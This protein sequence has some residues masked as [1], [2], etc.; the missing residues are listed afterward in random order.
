M[1]ISL[2]IT[3]LANDVRF[4]SNC[5]HCIIDDEEFPIKNCHRNNVA[6]NHHVVKTKPRARAKSTIKNRTRARDH[7]VFLELTFPF[8]FH[9]WI[10]Q[11]SMREVA[12][13]KSKAAFPRRYRD[14]PLSRKVAKNEAHTDLFTRRK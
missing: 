1:C 7:T 3:H 13:W 6:I 12:D 10:N 8:Y 2:L 9:W 11:I 5:I 14:F 4:F